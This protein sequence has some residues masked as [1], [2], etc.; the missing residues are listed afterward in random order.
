MRLENEYLA[1]T[2][3]TGRPPISQE[4][5]TL[6]IETVTKNAITRGWSCKKISQEI[7]RLGQPVAPRTVY[8]ILKAEDYAS[9]KLIVKPGLNKIIKEVRRDF[10]EKYKD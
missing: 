3:R 4:A 8:K 7:I 10:C 9:C 6:I 1:N 5:I 2:E